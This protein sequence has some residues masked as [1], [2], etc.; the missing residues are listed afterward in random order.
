MH[1]LL[2]AHLQDARAM[3]K[4]YQTILAETRWNFLDVPFGSALISMT[5]ERGRSRC[6][7]LIPYDMVVG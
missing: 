6:R 1:I 3:L 2:L 7:K 5:S 4:R